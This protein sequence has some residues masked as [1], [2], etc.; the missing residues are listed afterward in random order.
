MQ[1][2]HLLLD[3]LSDHVLLELTGV[4][5]WYVHMKLMLLDALSDH[6]LLVHTEASAWYVHINQLWDTSSD[7][8]C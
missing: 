7:Y 3:A 6:V 5:S 8:V 2:K 4:S 1:M